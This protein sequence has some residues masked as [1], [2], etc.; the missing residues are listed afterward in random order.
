MNKTLADLKRD[1]VGKKLILKEVSGIPKNEERT[2]I[3]LQG[4][5]FVFLKGDTQSKSYCQIPKATLV[6]Y[7]GETIKTFRPALRELT[8][9]EKKVMDNVPRDEEQERVDALS[10]GYVMGRKREMYYKEAGFNYLFG[11][12]KEKGKRLTHA[13][14]RPMIEDDNIKGDLELVYAFA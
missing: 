9:E 14:K 10:D 3:K 11:I 6:E 2:C 12:K 13:D 5:S 8:E 4:D 7:D 1:I